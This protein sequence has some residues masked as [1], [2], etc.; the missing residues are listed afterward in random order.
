[1]PNNR[2]VWIFFWLAYLKSFKVNVQL[3]YSRKSCVCLKNMLRSK[4]KI[5]YEILSIFT[6]RL[7][8]VL[9]LLSS[10]LNTWFWKMLPN[11]CFI[12]LCSFKGPN[13]AKLL[14]LPAECIL[15][16]N[17]VMYHSSW[18]IMFVMLLVWRF[19]LVNAIELS[20]LTPSSTFLT[21]R[22]TDCF[23]SCFLAWKRKLI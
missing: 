22:F 4:W 2:K 18:L 13:L 21:S 11:F 1:M 8:E 6:L 7:Q 20:V 3:I 16:C 9:L 14:P 10:T 17:N 12:W 15:W 5:F 19:V 23:I